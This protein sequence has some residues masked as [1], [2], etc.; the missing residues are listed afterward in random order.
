MEPKECHV[1][2]TTRWNRNTKNFV[3]VCVCA[4]TC[5]KTLIFSILGYCQGVDIKRKCSH[6]SLA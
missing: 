3:C 5:V 6:F 4:C 2:Q 1:T